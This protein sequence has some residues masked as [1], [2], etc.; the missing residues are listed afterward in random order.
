MRTAR[1]ARPGT[2]RSFTPFVIAAAAFV[3]VLAAFVLLALAAVAPDALGRGPDPGEVT[4]T[5]YW[6]SGAEDRFAFV[7]PCGNGDVVAAGLAQSATAQHVVVARYAPSGARR[8][9]RVV[10]PSTTYWDTPTAL[11]VDRAGN[12]L[13]AGMG[14]ATGGDADILVVKLRT[15]G[16]VAWTERIAV[17]ALTADMG[18][19]V[20]TDRD[21]NAYVACRSAGGGA[22]MGLV[23]KLRAR[24]GS[25]AWSREF[26]GEHALTTPASIATDA[27]GTSYVTGGGTVG[28]LGEMVTVRL[29]PAGGVRWT[30]EEPGLG[31]DSSTGLH[32]A[33]APRGALYVAGATGVTA[34]DSDV[35]MA[36]YTTTGARRW[37]DEL[38]VSDGAAWREV[39]TGLSV[40]R[41]GNAFIS[42]YGEPSPISADHGFAARWR[43]SGGRWYWDG[44]VSDETDTAL[45]CV[46]ADGAGGCYV[47]GRIVANYHEMGDEIEVGYFARLRADGSRAW[48]RAHAYVGGRTAF[49][50]MAVWPGS[51]VCLVGDTRSPDG[52]KRRALVQ[53]R[54]R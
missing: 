32:V 8:W 30:L 22:S 15:N 45:S 12:C 17:G 10:A 18:S 5:R 9:V 52:D 7:A 47:A 36:R 51:G 54:R 44:A 23:L 13:V 37:R 1:I 27:R 31:A 14:H 50:G 19:D 25:R 53:L 6:D 46:A 2:G 24:N 43:P 49:A 33:L 41:S 21:G 28:P 26:S 35:V 40:D 3:S 4:W 48:E 29:S 34:A 42:G 16:R 39:P 20:A 11:A 38:D